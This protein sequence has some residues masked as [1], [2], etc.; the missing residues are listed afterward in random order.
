L[1][2]ANVAASIKEGIALAREAIANGAAHQKMAQFVA[3][4]QKSGSPT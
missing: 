3:F 1:Y 2:A 4:T